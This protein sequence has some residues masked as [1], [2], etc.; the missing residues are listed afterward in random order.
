[1]PLDIVSSDEPPTKL[2]IDQDSQSAK[3]RDY[4]YRFRLAGVHE[5]GRLQPTPAR[6]AVDSARLLLLWKSNVGKR[7]N[8]GLELT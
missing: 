1:M 2:L 7:G 3:I 4:M 5:T 8:D 6:I